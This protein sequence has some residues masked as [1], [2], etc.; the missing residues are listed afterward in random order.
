MA[1]DPQITPEIEQLIR[2]SAASRSCLSL[3]AAAL[4]RRLDV[5]T[6][7]VHSLRRHPAAWLGGSLAT[8]LAASLLFRRKPAA[9]KP[10]RSLRRSLGRLALT[11]AGPLVKAWLTVQLKQFIAAQVLAAQVR[12]HASS[13]KPHRATLRASI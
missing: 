2:L 4:R 6:R 5:P 11:A 1:R 12:A 7:I 8:G 9:A 10:P 13:D 3:E